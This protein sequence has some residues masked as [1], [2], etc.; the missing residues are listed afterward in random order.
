M[1]REGLGERGWAWGE[2]GAVGKKLKLHLINCNK[3][4]K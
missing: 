3:K 1:A 2:G 4:L